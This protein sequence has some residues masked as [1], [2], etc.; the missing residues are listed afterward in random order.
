MAKRMNKPAPEGN[1]GG[2]GPPDQAV[3]DLITHELVK[4]VLV[5]A[6][7]GTGKTTSLV[8]RMINL[9][10]E[11]RC[12][13][14]KLA[15]VTFTR[16][17]AAELRSRFQ[18]G[19]E[20]AARE[21]VGIER[22]RLAVA[23]AHVE[24]CFLGTIHSFCGRL[25]RE[26]P[27]EAGV[28]SEFVELDDEKDWEMRRQAWSEHVDRLIA[29]DDP[30]FAAL[31]EL[32]LDIGQLRSTFERF[33]DYPDVVEWP[34][35]EISLPDPEP[36]LSALRG[37]VERM[38]SLAPTL[39][40]D[41]G[42]DKLI[43]EYRRYPRHV[44]QANLRRP[45]EL[46]AVL[47]PFSR[48][49]PAVVQKNWPG[50][51]AQA[52]AELE[53][54]TRF[55]QD[56]AIPYVEVSRWVRYNHILNV[57]RPAVVIYDRL[58]RDAGG[59]NFQDLLLTA[60]KTLRE[61]PPI[62]KYFR[63][64]FT[65]LL[66]DEFQ[67]TD[68]IQAEVMLLLTADD[69]N[70][71]NWRRCRP[72][73]GSLFVVGDPKQSIYRFRRA[74]IVTYSEV[75]R[76]IEDT[77]GHVV[78]LTANFRTTA[79]LVEWINQTFAKRFPS[80]ATEIA[81]AH[82]PLQVGRVD[83]RAGDLAGLYVLNAFGANKEEILGYETTVVARTIRHAVDS[84]R[85]VPRSQREREEP[86]TAQPGD[87]LIV[88]R[89][90]TNLSRYARELQALGVPHQ[91]TGGTALNEL[92]ELGLLC[93]CLRS[94]VRPDDPVALVAVLRSELFG[95]SD[96]AL[97]A[98][99]RAGGRFSLRRPVP[100]NGLSQ[101]DRGAIKDAFDRLGLYYRWLYLLPPASSV[102]KI[103]AH[104][105][106]L[107]R[108]FAAPGGDVRAGSLAK[109][110]ELVRFAEAEQL[111]VMDLVDYLNRLVISDQKHD[112]ISVRPPDGPVVR[113]MNLHKVKGLEA[114]IVFLSDPT[115]NYDHPV[116]LHI[117]RSGENV[118]G[119]MAVYGPKPN[120]G[121]A[122]L[123][124]L[125]CPSDWRRLETTERAFQQAENERLLYVAAT[126]AGACLVVARRG[127]GAKD[128]P[129]HSLTDDRSNQGIHE[130][131]GP[132]VPPTRP[133]VTVNAEEIEAAQKNID[134]RWNVSRRATYETEKIKEISLNRPRSFSDPIDDAPLVVSAQEDGELAEV[135]LTG[136]HGV[137][138]G[139]D[140][141]VLL[142]A[143]M[144]KP[145][146][147]L[148]SLARALARE[149]DGD[150]DRV[151]A[152]VTSVRN[153]QQSAIWKRA[154]A[155][156]RVL[157]EVPL[158]TM[159]PANETDTGRS[160]VRRGVIDLAFLEPQG[161]VIVDYKTD[162]AEPRLI[163]KLVEYYRP[164]VRSY[165]ATW[166]TLVGQPVHEVGLFFTYG[167]RYECLESQDSSG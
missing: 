91:V 111:S 70:E 51:K 132:Q 59:L 153:V 80:K 117:D 146:C 140:M 16:K 158:M 77:G 67:D 58:R 100:L 52:L 143:A 102:E 96:A 139:E 157:A 34:A 78:S 104:L 4:N 108:A 25:L 40:D 85:K 106:L 66:V 17:A 11:G 57:M 99:K 41:A 36:V 53:A 14:D 155:S 2:Q 101:E 82:A 118:R 115:G 110:F 103:A 105:G 20:K 42:N 35:D 116:D 127:Q 138:W 131:P 60:S 39:P 151:K 48:S 92:E 22:E 125:A 76:I 126:R 120:V 33:A 23:V 49:Q 12:P 133:R 149:R 160:T 148:E 142:E 154:Q 19:L 123:R 24:R 65:H 107:A 89:N 141:H 121:Y 114:P 37:Y 97:Y 18:V 145:D 112:G 152:L 10:R 7:A 43:P 74:D 54:W 81:P 9:I 119:Y 161:W 147:N 98:F 46:H 134:E 150:D 135:S 87:F 109:V 56:H 165:A 44:R 128:N 137:E 113:L 55:A 167:N 21:A 68:P 50:G 93:T 162:H 73:N 5:E 31:E 124:L 84:Q 29:S 94:L 122:P 6:A 64:R 8:A 69:P 1:G 27:V 83:E 38:E 136:E 71:T 88:T 61:N 63:S 15:A 144:R 166:R 62:R 26:R 13:I 156:Q 28:D 72:V 75:K 86:E 130:D 30:L 3:R 90:T 47:D 45:G 164:Q 79:P 129:W 163:P 32:G 95:I 159:V